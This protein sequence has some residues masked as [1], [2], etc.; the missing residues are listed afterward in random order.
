MVVVLPAPCRPTIIIATGGL[1]ARLIGSASPPSV[2]MRT[3]LTILTTIWPGETDLIT[4]APTARSRTLSVK[5]R[6]TSSA[7]SASRSARRISFRAS[8][9]SLSLRALRRVSRSK[10]PE[11]FSERLSNINFSPTDQDLNEADP[12]AKPARGRIALPSVGPP[13]HE[14]LGC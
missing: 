6:T 1:A 8:A 5:E 9:T 11:S 12:N 2:S 3:S 13:F 7:T 4:P 10:T 14:R